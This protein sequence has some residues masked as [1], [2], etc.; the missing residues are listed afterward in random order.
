MSRVVL[1]LILLCSFQYSIS[2]A[3]KI[4]PNILV[5][6][7]DDLGYGDVGYTGST[8]IQTPRI[9]DLALNGVICKNGYVTHP[10]CGPS[11][12]GLITGRYQARFGMEVNCAYSPYDV[13]LGLPLSEKTFGERMQEK[14]ISNRDY[15]EVAFGC[16]T[17]FSSQ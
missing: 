8:E 4:L 14:G 5:I 15:W 10:Y 3:D 6:L 17:P 13:K 9:D 7:A 16:C 2:R 12:A 1:F 11:R